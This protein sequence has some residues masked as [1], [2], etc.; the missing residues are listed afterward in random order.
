MGPAV[1]SYRF[2]R[3][4]SAYR[5]FPRAV[6]GRRSALVPDGEAV[7]RLEGRVEAVDA[8]AG[9]LA[10]YRDVCGFADD[11]CLPI[12]YPHV[13]TM[14]LHFAIL[15]H[16]KFPV[17]LM[18]LIH[19]ANQ[20]EQSRPMPADRTYGVSTW[21]EGHR[22]TDRGQEFDVFT[23]VDDSQ[24]RAWFEKMTLLARRR[25]SG[26]PA[27][28]SARQALRYEKPAEGAAVDSA[29]IDV[30]RA[31]GRRYGWLSGD[32]NPIH[33][34]DR[35][36]RLFG[37]ER[38]VAHGM[39]SMARSFAALGRDALAPPVTAQVEFKFPLFM[40][41]VARLEHWSGEERSVFVL[42]DGESGRP[43]LAGS[44]RRR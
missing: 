5:Y 10:R 12:T 6:F 23:A 21:I 35:G 19:L 34:G 32:L 40:P 26:K 9:H 44:A 8:N 16:P 17:R 1:V 14:P 20:I 39:W 13:I 37:F 28:R 7:P 18:G 43:H 42:K 27:S 24:G 2:K 22:E 36:A 4:P 41:A 15:T 30:P 31:M 29:D 25:A 3:L 33:L 11:G 38:A